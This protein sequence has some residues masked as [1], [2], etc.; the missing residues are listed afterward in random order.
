MP[1]NKSSGLPALP[2]PWIGSTSRSVCWHLPCC[3]S[4][5]GW[6]L[7]LCCSFPCLAFSDIEDSCVNHIQYFLAF[8]PSP[9]FLV[10]SLF[11]LL[12]LG[13]GLVVLSSSKPPVLYWAAPS[14]NCCV[15]THPWS[16]AKAA[17]VCV[18]CLMRN[19]EMEHFPWGLCAFAIGLVHGP[20][21]SL[22]WRAVTQLNPK[23]TSVQ[24]LRAPAPKAAFPSN[25]QE[26]WSEILGLFTTVSALFY[27]IKEP[28][29]SLTKAIAAIEVQLL[30][31]LRMMAK[32]P[33]SLQI[34]D[35]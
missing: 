16:C 7:P 30:F 35:S 8:H 21:C 5:T 2:R 4:G 14:A 17:M 29:W 13:S 6:A 1:Q 24:W 3:S 34:C 20:A 22:S 28:D 11:H 12:L 27:S 25:H 32:Y 23:G 33:F 26:N 15:T 19:W 9:L 18:I 10:N 31:G